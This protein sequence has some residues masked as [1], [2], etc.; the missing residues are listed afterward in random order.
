MGL[1]YNE[2]LPLKNDRLCVSHMLKYLNSFK[3][4]YHGKLLFN[5]TYR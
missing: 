1:R 2:R 5:I 3:C 4:H